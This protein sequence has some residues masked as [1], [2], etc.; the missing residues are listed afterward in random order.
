M[1]KRF[2]D[3]SSSQTSVQTELSAGD[4]V[5]V[6]LLHDALLFAHPYVIHP[7]SCLRLFQLR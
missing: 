3:L 5:H 2:L 1:G 6:S 4:L 7:C